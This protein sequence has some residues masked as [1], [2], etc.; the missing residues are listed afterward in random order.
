MNPENFH[1][2]QEIIYKTV[3]QTDILNSPELQYTL[4]PQDSAESNLNP[5]AIVMRTSSLNQIAPVLRDCQHQQ[6][7]SAVVN[8]LQSMSDRENNGMVDPAYP[9]QLDSKVVED[10]DIA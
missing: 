8:S 7:P 1:E 2:I 6:S 10:M 5:N 3:T 4:Q 9:Y